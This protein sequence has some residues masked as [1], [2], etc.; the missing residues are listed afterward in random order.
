MGARLANPIR[1]DTIRTT[2][3]VD[4]TVTP[5]R[6]RGEGD[7]EGEAAGSFLVLLLDVAEAATIDATRSTAGDMGYENSWGREPVVR[8]AP[9]RRLN[10]DHK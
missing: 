6:V 9:P 8:S 4:E 10:T 2:S 7:R 5:P 1:R 3:V